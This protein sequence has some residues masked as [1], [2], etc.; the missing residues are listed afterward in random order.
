MTGGNEVK[1]TFCGHSEITQP[2]TVLDWLRNVV[3][4]LIA[5]G[6]DVFFLGDYGAFDRMAAEVI[7]EEKVTNTNLEMVLV[8]PY[9][10]SN[11]DASGYDC[12]VYPPLESV[13]P[14]FAVSRRN[15]WMVEQA[16]A[17]V[18]CVTHNWGGA[19]RTLDYAKQKQKEIFLYHT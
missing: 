13:P 2:E 5:E 16:D 10:N 8:L 12:S 4:R 3:R 7:R 14:R 19:A 11:L 1:V 9:L 15:R 18:A 6:A 17:V